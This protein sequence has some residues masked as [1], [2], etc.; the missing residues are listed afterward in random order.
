MSNGYGNRRQ[1][2]GDSSKGLPQGYL[3][4]GY[5]ESDGHIKEALLTTAADSIGKSF[6]QGYPKMTT[7]QLRRFYGHA[8]TAE[9]GYQF[10]ADEKK[11]VLDIKALESV[12][13][14]AQG[15]KKV[16]REFY[17]FIKKNTDTIKDGKDVLKG[18][19]PH[20]QAVVAFFTYHNPGS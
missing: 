2:Q 8:K 3:Q 4:G 20:F 1:G 7:G 13:A 10:T 18:F 9:K 16:P 11:L 19:L 15:K 5:F 14:E 12:V 17:Q 6:G